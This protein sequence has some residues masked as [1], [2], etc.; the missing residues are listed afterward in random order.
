M[1]AVIDLWPVVDGHYAQEGYRAAFGMM[2]ALQVV[3]TA[4][5]FSSGRDR[6]TER[7]NGG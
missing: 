6:A 7:A 1:G 5:Y 4:W 3:A 2:L